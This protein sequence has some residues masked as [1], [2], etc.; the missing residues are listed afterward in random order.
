[1]A[2]GDENVTIRIN[3][4][5]DTS[6]IDR[7][8]RKLAQLC[9]EA[10]SCEK[11][12]NRYSRSVN[13]AGDAHRDL[14]RRST[15]TTKALRGMGRE[16]NGLA[17]ILKT[18]YK[19]AFIAA[20][21]ETAALALALSSVNGL[22]ATGR[23]LVKSYHVAMSALAKAAAAA[24]VALATVAAAQRQFVAAQATGRYGGSFAASSAGLRT[25]TGDARLASLGMKALTGAF[26]A[27]SK[28]AR[29]TGGTASAI[30]GLMDFAVASGDIEKGA[31]AVAN[32]VSL[33]QKGGA[34]QKGVLEAA[35]ELG[36]E[37]E[38]AFK[39]ASK[40]GKA[41]S[42]E[43]M[44]MFSSGEL[45]QK[46]G[47]AGGF[48]ATRGSLVGQLKA[49]MTEMQ[50]MFGDLGTRFIEPVQ[51]AFAEIRQIMTRTVTQLM[52]LL[53]NFAQDTMIDK[54]V[55]GVD[56]MAQFLVTL[57]QDY[58]P[59]T[60]GFFDAM[61]RGWTRFTDGLERFNAYLR[62][63]SEASKIV[64]KFL[65]QIF[66]AIGSGL[67][68]NFEAFAVM[69]VDNR[70]DFD[71][72]GRSIAN[73]ITQI[74]N[75]FNAI[76]EAFMRALPA[77]TTLANVIANMVQSIAD[78]LRMV[79]SIPSGGLGLGGLAALM[80]PMAAGLGG[81]GARRG[82]GGR[83][84]MGTGAKLGIGAGILGAAGLAQ[85]PGVGTTVGSMASAG[86]LA[87][88]FAP[89]GKLATAK[90]GAI[91]K[92]LPFAIGAAGLVGT[93]AAT[94]AVYR[95]TGGNRAAT[96]AVGA[97]G[98]AA[99]GA[100]VGQMMIPVPVIGAAIGALGGALIGG[101]MGLA[102]DKKYKD[103]AKKAGQ[104]FVDTYA[105]SVESML[106]GNDLEAA[107]KA[108]DDFK[109]QAQAMADTQVKS[110]TALKEATKQWE[111]RSKGLNDS[112]KLMGAR[113]GDLER[114][115][116]MTTD[117]IRD[118]ANAAEVD[119][120][121]G[122]LTLK[123]ILE[124][125][126]IATVRFGED[127][128]R[129]LTNSFA[130]AVAG[131]QQGVD[132][133]KAPQVI[134]EAAQSLR[135]QA[136]SGTLTSESLGAGL[137]AIMQQQLLISGGDPLAAFEQLTKDLGITGGGGGQ[138]NTPGNVFYD[139]SGRIRS[140][141]QGAGFET[142]RGQA[143][144]AVQGDL[145]TLAAENIIGGAA[146]VGMSLGISKEAL[147]AQLSGMGASELIALSK[148]LR[149][150]PA[151]TS[152]GG[153]QAGGRQGGGVDFN[154]QLANLL[155]GEIAKVLK[156][157]KTDE[158]KMR[159]SMSAF[160]NAVT[161]FGGIRDSFARAVNNFQTAVD[162]FQAGG[163][164]SSPRR[165]IVNTLGAH[166]RFDSM[167]AGSRTVTSGYRTWG[168]GSMS[169][170]HAAGRAYDLTGQNLGLYQ[171]AVKASGGFAEFHGTGGGRHLHVV[172]NTSLAPIGD[173][174]S[175]YA[176]GGSTTGTMNNMTVNMTV[177]AAPGMDAT[178]LANEVMAQI[179]RAQRSMRERR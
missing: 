26:A 52:P 97:L 115:T 101:I 100:L 7:V 177:N 41:T 137:Q 51:R 148:T 174:A 166:S 59:K 121:S 141:F 43:L 143:F 77:I 146:G 42:A 94:D 19:F 104:A 147:V 129:A 162:D 45:A 155:G 120:G 169:S 57:M 34:G 21:I 175:P 90:G 6:A 98:G 114:I 3:V 14:D 39:A 134:N 170:D 96:T 50:V 110:G 73:L 82:P 165:N 9:A 128:N 136:L 10:D 86:L 22:L 20:G 163:D 139:P 11:T 88:M 130:N 153:V 78:L 144:G 23:F 176:G 55:N 145:A 75:M 28:N 179:E 60:Q 81:R 154:V 33:V 142:L 15:D 116:G 172:P 8:R 99:T 131:I 56:K 140:A 58:V 106:A 32:L 93:N 12:F 71:R 119:L 160:G 13:D 65:G 24:G 112:I 1:M 76:R 49:F 156:P 135:E 27:A 54:I 80:L 53:N 63:F 102:K 168:L 122:M 91:P 138:F 158:Q 35:K 92:A 37:F 17:R 66:G 126:G 40:G 149:A 74:F 5:A 61:S 67:R 2:I 108:M 87:A 36:P 47:L 132:I 83:T 18:S 84:P 95:A 72:F 157:D 178:A 124:A 68:T 113:F 16:A 127:F 150:G 70:D 85:I 89:A 29:V 38:K 69:L 30:A 167:I 4:K 105:R 173:M 64:N 48:A 79:T 31:A 123:Q 161:G 151:F 46:A 152:P 125:T 117:Q 171:M 111:T 103:Q 109:A 25:L 118:L 133:L 62:R 164:T 107:T 159:D 44:K